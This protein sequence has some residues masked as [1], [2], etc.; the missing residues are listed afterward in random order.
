MSDSECNDASAMALSLIAGYSSENSDSDDS[1]DGIS[2]VIHKTPQPRKQSYGNKENNLIGK[3]RHHPSS[4]TPAVPTPGGGRGRGVKVQRTESVLD[5]VH[6]PE[7]EEKVERVP[8]PSTVLTMFD[9]TAEQEALDQ[10]QYQGRIR[11]FPHEKNNWAS[12]FYIDASDL[13]LDDIRKF[14]LEELD[15]VEPTEDAHVSLS[16]TVSLRH[17]WID[18][19]IQGV[20]NGAKDVDRFTVK[21][22]KLQVYCNDERTRTFV[23]LKASN[24]TGIKQLNKVTQVIN[25]IFTQFSLP[26]FY[27][28]ASFH[29]SLVWCLGDKTKELGALLPSLEMKML[30]IIEDVDDFGKVFIKM[31]HCKSGNRFFDF[32]LK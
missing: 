22:D 20:T 30:D 31:A 10:A 7:M 29:V 14:L 23:G 21:L 12:F 5:N 27:N 26:K 28:P 15:M 19:I 25:N 16:R 1:D 32:K 6:R 8:L 13:D 3:K 2:V 17:H 4:T 18:P 24:T 11:S 9:K